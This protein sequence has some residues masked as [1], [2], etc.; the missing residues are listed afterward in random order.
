M[1]IL[2]S[3]AYPATN[4]TARRNESAISQALSLLRDG[5]TPSRCQVVLA[6]ASTL[7]FDPDAPLDYSD[8]PP[9]AL[10]VLLRAHRP[11]AITGRR[12]PRHL[13]DIQADLGTHQGQPAPVDG[14]WLAGWW[15]AAGA[16]VWGTDQKHSV[17]DRALAQG[18]V[19]LV[20]RLMEMPQAPGARELMASPALV[21]DARGWFEEAPRTWWAELMRQPVYGVAMLDALVQHGA[22]RPAGDQAW[23]DEAA[24][25]VVA[26]YA[27]Q[28]ALPKESAAQARLARSWKGRVAERHL[29]PTDLESM[30][31][32]LGLSSHHAQQ[33]GRTSALRQWLIDFTAGPPPDSSLLTHAIRL[34]QGRLRGQWNGLGAYI[35]GS[36]LSSAATRYY[37]VFSLAW[38]ALGT[39]WDAL[40]PA[41]VERMLAHEWRPGVSMRAMLALGFAVTPPKEQETAW[42]R[43]LGV[44]SLSD[45]CTLYFAEMVELCQQMVPPAS[46]ADHFSA[47]R[48]IWGAAWTHLPTTL[49]W[50]GRQKL[51][52]VFQPSSPA[53]TW[54]EKWAETPCPETPE[55]AWR[56]GLI[57][58]QSAN[59]SDFMGKKG[60]ALVEA[61]LDQHPVFQD[62]A[63]APPAGAWQAWL[64]QAD[65]PPSIRARCE[66][67][68]MD[69]IIQPSQ[70]PARKPRL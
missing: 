2:P 53:P 35:M 32:C 24:P 34:S 41:E 1:P 5:A 49:S 10:D 70:A 3:I 15:V 21:K 56:H 17:L 63:L 6:V 48:N 25:E 13:N 67:L 52:Q 33:E 22:R 11:L 65:L 37:A 16:S 58:L 64:K 28:D 4:Y 50:E 69:Q 7:E 18:C 55:D 57:A 8:H 31:G 68:M 59:T 62:P 39:A 12:L 40:A 51:A 26:W 36:L 60:P 19:A 14:E 9:R 45:W 20:D 27:A 47:W 30:L 46:A 61:V 66:A 29:S 38:E 54:V 44:D 23:L 43:R 42:R